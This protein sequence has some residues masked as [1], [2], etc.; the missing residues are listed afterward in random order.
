MPTHDEARA[1]LD[2]WQAQVD[3]P[4]AIFI[5]PDTLEAIA[6]LRALVEER[7]R[8]VVLY[9][10]PGDA[11]I[12]DEFSAASNEATPRLCIPISLEDAP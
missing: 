12:V 5:L 8:G 6:T 7:E 2:L 1:A 10:C 9:I 4:D 11:D 3:E